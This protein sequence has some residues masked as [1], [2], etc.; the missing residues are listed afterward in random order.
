MGDPPIQR[1]FQATVRSPQYRLRID[2][3]SP[4]RADIETQFAALLRGRQGIRSA[5]TTAARRPVGRRWRAMTTSARPTHRA[6][7]LRATSRRQMMPPRSSPTSTIIGKGAVIMAKT[8]VPDLNSPEFASL[9]SHL[10]RAFITHK[11]ELGP[12][13]A[14]SSDQAILDRT[15]D[16]MAVLLSGMARAQANRNVAWLRRYAWFVDLV[17]GLANDQP[18]KPLDA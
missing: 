16:I 8:D 2:L 6:R 12:E 9:R 4:S 5:P 15:D 10:A 3:A 11:A 18:G 14:A 7:S 17:E 1:A 13:A